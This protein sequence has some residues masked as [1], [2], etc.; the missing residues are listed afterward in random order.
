M[1][2]ARISRSVKSL[3]LFLAMVD[4][5]GG[6]EASQRNYSRGRRESDGSGG[7]SFTGRRFIVWPPERRRHDATA[8]LDEKIFPARIL[9]WKR[10]DDC[11]GRGHGRNR[12][13]RFAGEF[14]GG[15]R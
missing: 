7:W 15:S 12:T 8:E 10:C 13:R 1:A 2:S 11:S 14:A 3:K 4:A 6:V 9:D 5:P